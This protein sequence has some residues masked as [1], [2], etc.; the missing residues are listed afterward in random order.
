MSKLVR[1]LAVALVLGAFALAP[2]TAQAQFG[3]TWW[4]TFWNNTGWSGGSAGSFSTTAPLA[5]NWGMGSPM[6][7]V[8]ADNFTMRATT[9]VWMAPGTYLFTVQADDEVALIINGT[10]VL[11]T[12][13]QGQSGKTLT[14]QVPIWSNNF[15]RVEV[16]YREFTQLAYIFLSWQMIGAQPPVVPPGPGTLTPITGAQSVQTRFGDYTPCIAAGNHQKTCFVTDGQWDSP[17]FGSIEMEPP[18]TQWGNCTSRS[19][20]NRQLYVERPPQSAACSATEAGW[21]AR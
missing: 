17:N 10:A 12:R 14:V 18:I 7:G 2:A 16:E 20:E 4:L 6:S 11:D 15:Q 13:G 3:N 5:F 19:V 1:I 21:F 9:D 8:D